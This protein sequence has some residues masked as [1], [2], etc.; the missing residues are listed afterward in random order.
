MKKV[1]ILTISGGVLQQIDTTDNNHTFILIDWD[2]IK[3]GDKP[4]IYPEKIITMEEAN[5]IIV[6]AGGEAIEISKSE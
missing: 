5:K 2:N 6:D 1:T 3:Y 4:E